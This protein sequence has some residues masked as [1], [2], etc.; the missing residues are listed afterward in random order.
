MVLTTIIVIIHLLIC[1]LQSKLSVTFKINMAY[2]VFLNLF[3]LL[4][5]LFFKIKFPKKTKM[6]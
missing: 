1:E 6:Y 4:R 5:L 2:Q 3:L